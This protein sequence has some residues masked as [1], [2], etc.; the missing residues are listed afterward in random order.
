MCPGQFGHPD[1]DGPGTPALVCRS[2]AS[3]RAEVGFRT[4]LRRRGAHM[5]GN[6]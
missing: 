5:E 4:R 1:N 6:R 3:A 2:Y